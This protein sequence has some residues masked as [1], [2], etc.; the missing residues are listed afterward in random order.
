MLRLRRL[1]EMRQLDADRLE[2]VL[3]EAA[4]VEAVVRGGG[5]EEVASSHL[6]ARPLDDDI[7]RQIREK[8]LDAQN[9]GVQRQQALYEERLNA[10]SDDRDLRV[11]EAV[12]AQ[13]RF[14]LALA[15]VAQMQ[16]RL[17]SSEDRR[18]ELETGIDVVQDKCAMIEHRNAQH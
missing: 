15:Q 7:G 18:R 10:L 3:R 13:E 6:F 2:D 17:L 16:A 4:A 9:F 12:R 11:E 5:G 8:S 14:N 1:V